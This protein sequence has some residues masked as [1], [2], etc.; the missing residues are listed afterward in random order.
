M[1]DAFPVRLRVP[2]CSCCSSLGLEC[3]CKHVLPTPLACFW[4]QHSFV[5]FSVCVSASLVHLARATARSAMGLRIASEIMR[6]YAL[7]GAPA[8]SATKDSVLFWQ[9]TRPSPVS[10]L[11]SRSRV[12]CRLALLRLVPAR[13]GRVLPCGRRPADVFLPN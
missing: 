11:R 5:C 10:L 4:S 12:C 9:S 1:L 7:V 2:T 6:G 8:A 3:G 13:P